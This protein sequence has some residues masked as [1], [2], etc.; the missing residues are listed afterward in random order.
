LA[1]RDDLWHVKA[2]ERGYVRVPVTID[3][4]GH[5]VYM[6]VHVVRGA[7]P[8]PTVT[9]ISCLH[10]NEWLSIEVLRRVLDRV[11]PGALTGNLLA[12]TVGNPVALT[13]NRRN[14][15]DD[16]DAPDLNRS[17]GSPWNWL[18]EQLARTFAEEIFTRSDLIL[19]FHTLCWGSAFGVVIFGNDAPDAELNRRTDEL[20][21]VY[22]YPMLHG[23]PRNPRTATG[24]AGGMGIPAITIEIGGAGFGDAVEDAWLEENV[25]GVFN[26]LHHYRMLP[27]EVR[28]PREYYYWGKRWRIAPKH[29]GYLHSLVSPDR[30]LGE[31]GQ[32]E[33]LGTVVS[34]MSL[35]VLEELRAPG[36]GLLYCVGRSYPVRPGEWA[37][38]VA[39][40][41]TMRVVPGGL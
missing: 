22:G 25:A 34:P 36:R 31:V 11:Q 19:D 28:V 8:G 10:G 1:Q 13:T 30:L 27:G 4:G 40:L 14:T 3:L 21:R 17:F 39:D 16:S 9:L 33:L 38:G 23:G 12:V 26:V 35:E 15:P 32:D 5:E 20:A 41:D 18:A 6:P 24:H 2:T 7:R 37:F 29:G